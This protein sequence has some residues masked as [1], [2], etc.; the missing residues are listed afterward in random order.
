MAEKRKD[1]NGYVLRRGECVSADGRYSYSYVDNERKRHVVYA[2]NIVELREKEKEILRDR[3]DGIDA[4]MAR[5]MTL[6]DLYDRYISQKFNLKETT[7][8]GY[9][10]YYNSYVRY[11]GDGQGVQHE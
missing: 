4:G 5:R 6:N 7:L 3:D 2:K 8:A 9:I 10:Y 11:F 1:K